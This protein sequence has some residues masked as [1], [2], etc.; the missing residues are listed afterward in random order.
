[1]VDF[2]NWLRQEKNGLRNDFYAYPKE[3]ILWRTLGILLLF[4]AIFRLWTLL[5]F[6][7][8]TQWDIWLVNQIEQ[9]RNSTLDIFFLFLSNLASG[10]FIIVSFLILAFFLVRKKMKKAAFT[11]FLTLVGS[12]LFIWILK[13][14]FSRSRPFGCL[15]EQDCFSFPSGHAT[16]AFYFYGMLLNLI[17]RFLKFRKRTVFILGL[18]FAFL[19]F[20]I[21]ASRIYLGYHFL[22]DILGGFLLG[23][24]F[25]LLAALIIDFLYQ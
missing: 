1:M 18:F 3:K 4:L 14:F 8:M 10:Y 24:V 12:G 5:S 20:L 11:A 19:V 25:L 22:T 21:A 6:Q 9:L 7:K 2:K 16:M 23:G 15:S 13:N 17:T